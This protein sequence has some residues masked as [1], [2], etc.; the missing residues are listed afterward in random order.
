VT[1]PVISV[2]GLSSGTAEHHGHPMRQRVAG[3]AAESAANRPGQ[4]STRCRDLW[5]WSAPGGGGTLVAD[6]PAQ[7]EGW[8]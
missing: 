2:E 8:W 7:G 1:D 3:A 6:E 4:R 5:P